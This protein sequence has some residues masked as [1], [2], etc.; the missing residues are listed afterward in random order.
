ML[1]LSLRHVFVVAAA[2]AV[3]YKIVFAFASVITA[4]AVAVAV[5]VN[6]FSQILEKITMFILINEYLNVLYLV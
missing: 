2:F 5:N 1:L 4:V 6:V 3:Y